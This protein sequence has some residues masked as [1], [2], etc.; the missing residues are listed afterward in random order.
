MESY[1]LERTTRD[2]SSPTS[3]SSR[4]RGS[5]ISRPFP[6]KVLSI[7]KDG[8]PTISPGLSQFDHPCGLKERT[9]QLLSSCNFP[10]SHLCLLP[11]ILAWGTSKMS[12]TLLSSYPP[13]RQQQAAAGYPPSPS[14]SGLNKPCS[15]SLSW[16]LVAPCY[17]QVCPCLFSA[18][19]PKAE[20]YSS[21][22]TPDSQVLSRGKH[23]F[24]AIAGSAS[25]CPSYKPKLSVWCSHNR[26][27]FAVVQLSLI[28]LCFL[29]LIQCPEFRF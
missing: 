16:Q 20:Q 21:C 10:C 27:G 1:K 9:K 14:F 24:P 6:N 26:C 12:Q 17:S 3:C 29:T 25:S 23:H 11:L 8:D 13:V 19:D 18:E 5:R 22:I 2:F 7:L 28:P 4:S 15:L